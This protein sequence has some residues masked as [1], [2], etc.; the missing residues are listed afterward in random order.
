MRALEPYCLCSNS[1]FT[2]YWSVFLLNVT[3]WSKPHFPSFQKG[4]GSSTYL[5]SLLWVFVTLILVN[6]LE[7]CQARSKCSELLMCQR[8]FQKH[9]LKEN[10]VTNLKC[11]VIVSLHIFAYLSLNAARCMYV[12]VYS[13]NSQKCV[14]LLRKVNGD[15][16]LMGKK[17]LKLKFNFL[18]FF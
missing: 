2:T 5:I 6:H 3:K 7:S 10:M 1:N 17:V 8:V 13:D 4:Y 18:V 11:L 15:G 12:C 9:V 14:Y 16:N